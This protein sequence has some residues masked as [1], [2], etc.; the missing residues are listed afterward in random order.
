MNEEGYHVCGRPRVLLI[1]EHS[2]HM[3]IEHST[4]ALREYMAICL[5]VNGGISPKRLLRFLTSK[6]NTFAIHDYT[7]NFQYLVFSRKTFSRL[8]L[9]KELECIS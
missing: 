6:S 4:C 1:H 9:S 8:Y 7:S 3:I 2:L 5:M